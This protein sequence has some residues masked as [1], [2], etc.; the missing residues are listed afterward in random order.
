MPKGLLLAAPPAD[1]TVFMRDVKSLAPEVGKLKIP[2]GKFI[3]LAAL[4]QFSG[5]EISKRIGRHLKRKTKKKKG[6]DTMVI[7]VA[8]AIECVDKYFR[9]PATIRGL[10]EETI[11][12]IVALG[13]SFIG[14]PPDDVLGEAADKCADCIRENALRQDTP[15]AAHRTTK[16]GR[17]ARGHGHGRVQNL[18]PFPSRR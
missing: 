15:R 4:N 11:S 5:K 2:I 13:E 6:D 8:E 14:K 18:H 3:G 16:K 7:K 10:A 1:P 12:I 17:P 9:D